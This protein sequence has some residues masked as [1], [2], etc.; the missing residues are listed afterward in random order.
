MLNDRQAHIALQRTLASIADTRAQAAIRLAPQKRKTAASAARRSMGEL[1][2][3]E[4]RA[5]G[6][7][8]ATTRTGIQIGSAHVA[9]PTKDW[10]GA[11]GPYRKRGMPLGERLFIAAMS[12]VAVALLALMV[13]EHP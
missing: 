10:A 1:Y 4:L 9:P 7:R 2:A 5:A 12:G 6:E 11:F 13:W 8:F 3:P